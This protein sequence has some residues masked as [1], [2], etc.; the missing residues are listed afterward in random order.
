MCVCVEPFQYPSS[1]S[2]FASAGSKRVF[3]WQMSI[4]DSMAGKSLTGGEKQWAEK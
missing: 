4:L 2:G 3:A 1:L